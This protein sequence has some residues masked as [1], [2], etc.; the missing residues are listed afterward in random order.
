MRGDSEL[1]GAA[2][3]AMSPRSAR[4][5]LEPDDAEVRHVADA[6]AYERSRRR[7]R[8]L[9]NPRAEVAV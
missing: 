3:A 6:I 2:D 9:P 1:A 4:P 7:R 8:K 5:L